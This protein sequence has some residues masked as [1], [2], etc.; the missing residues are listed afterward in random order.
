MRVR[1]LDNNGRPLGAL[2][3]GREP[4][5]APTPA[6]ARG[7]KGKL[8]AGGA[9]V[10]LALGVLG[11]TGE[12]TGEDTAPVPA[13]VAL[14]E[15]V[16]TYS[17]STPADAASG[18][19][20]V[21]LASNG[22]VR[23]NGTAMGNVHDEDNPHRARYLASLE[24]SGEGVGVASSAVSEGVRFCLAL[25]RGDTVALREHADIRAGGSLYGTAGRRLAVA[26]AATTYFCPSFA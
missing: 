1:I 24:A 11:S 17:G 18:W 2:A 22:E 5:P 6:P 9:L 19:Q 25:Q 10:I 4:H 13:T 12:D 20:S 16:A 15:P 14:P 26:H 3:I 23:L 21:T 7:G 8:V